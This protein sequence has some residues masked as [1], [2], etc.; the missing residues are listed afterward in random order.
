MELVSKAFNSSE[1]VDLRT[2]RESNICV[3][4]VELHQLL[5]G[6]H[7]CL[8]VSGKEV[9]PRWLKVVI[10]RVESAVLL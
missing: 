7:R 9:I 5:L 6:A 8:L 4:S 1:C 3:F 10:W 2:R